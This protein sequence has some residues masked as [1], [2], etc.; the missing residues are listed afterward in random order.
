MLAQGGHIVNLTTTLV[1]RPV[2]G[3]PSA[4]ASLSF[5]MQRRQNVR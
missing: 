3:V 5:P 1:D 2:K 4:L